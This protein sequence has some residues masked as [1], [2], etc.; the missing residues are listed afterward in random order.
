MIR[1]L[2]NEEKN[3]KKKKMEEINIETYQ[4]ITK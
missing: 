1:K 2:S 3:M 4:K